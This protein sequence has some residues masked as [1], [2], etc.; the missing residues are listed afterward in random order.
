MSSALSELRGFLSA[1]GIARMK[2]GSPAGDGLPRTRAALRDLNDSSDS[3]VNAMSV[4]PP[5]LNESRGGLTLLGKPW[6]CANGR[7]GKEIHRVP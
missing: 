2:L 3:P 7:I 1:Y 6:R 5:M 4:Q